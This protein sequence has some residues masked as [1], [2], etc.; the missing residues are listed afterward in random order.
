L[1]KLKVPYRCA[2]EDARCYF[3]QGESVSTH[4]LH[5]K[6]LYMR[7]FVSDTRELLSVRLI[8]RVLAAD[9]DWHRRIKPDFLTVTYV[10]SGETLVRIND[11][12]FLAEP[13]DLIL[14]PP[15]SDY[16]FGT[17]KESLRSAVVL[18]GDMLEG[19]LH[20]FGGNLVFSDNAGH[21]LE[22]MM[23][24]FLHSDEVDTKTLAVWSFELLSSLHKKDEDAARPAALECVIGRMKAD[25]EKPLRSGD[26]AAEANVTPRTLTRLFL[27]HLHCSP[28]Q[29]LTALRM[30][31]ARQML[32]WEEFSIK[33]IAISAGFRD[34]LNFSTSFR[35]YFG[36]SPS[37]YRLQKRPV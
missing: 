29:Y 3:R 36:C 13:G 21:D 25:L 11:H 22:K 14:M 35:K 2:P 34:A 31:K 33:E 10:H 20:H 9:G 4:T 24:R 37:D 28:H 17:P 32:V 12:S 8:C 30:E 18:I 15:G 27:K 16:E 23:E 7:H 19:L 1:K 6:N 5:Q 26:L